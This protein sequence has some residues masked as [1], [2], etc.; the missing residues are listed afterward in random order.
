M[1]VKQRSRAPNL[2]DQTIERIV[3]IL[4]GW[5]NAKHLGTFLSN[6]SFCGIEL[7][8]LAKAT[9]SCSNQDA[10]SYCKKKLSGPNFKEQKALSPTSSNRSL[11]SKLKMNV[12]NGKT[13]TCW[14]SSTDGSITDI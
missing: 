13:T 14:S 2:N 9:Q 3:E 1:T 4:D 6:R 7:P 10:F 12:S 11:V 8:T 5:S